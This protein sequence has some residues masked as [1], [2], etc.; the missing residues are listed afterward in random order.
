M[1]RG[2]GGG[3][4]SGGG[5]SSHS[6]HSGGGGSLSGR[7]HSSGGSFGGGRPSGG[8]HH[9]SGGGGGRPYGG[10]PPRYGGHYGAPPPP[11]PPP[12]GG[13]GYYRRPARRSSGCSLGVV[14]VIF[15]ILVIGFVV[16]SCGS[17]F[18]FASGVTRSTEK[19]DK[20]DSKYVNY[21][22]T[23]YEDE[24]GWFGKNNN[25]VINGLEDFYQSTGIQPYICL[26]SY[27]SVED[28][29]SARDEYIEKK[30]SELFTDEGHMLFCY[31]ACQND[32]P[33][34]M[35]GNWLYIVGKQTETVMDENAKQIFESYFKKYYD[36]TSLDVDELFAD[37]FSDSGK[38]IMRGPIHMRYVVIIIVAIVAAVII[39][40]MLFKWWKARK[41]QK[42]KEQEDLERMLDKPLETFGT[43]K[44]V[45]ELKDKYDDKK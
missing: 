43:D 45:D 23:W 13:G 29:A 12:H 22:N 10:P 19:R 17:V 32:K 9:Y 35:D 5:G 1:A 27:D 25:T 8:G 44:V 33:D 15:V 3:G 34:V 40:A 30:Y 24:L 20:L 38:A 37:T 28:N 6:S 14:L 26:V 16:K 18:G 42:N 4:H 41:A 11:P 2:G 36:D 39:V 21:S 31:F 7:G